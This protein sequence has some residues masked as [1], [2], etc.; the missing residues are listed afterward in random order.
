MVQNPL[1]HV[2]RSLVGS[3]AI[4]VSKRERHLSRVQAMTSGDINIRRDGFLR[5]LTAIADKHD[6]PRIVTIQNPY[7]LLN[8]SF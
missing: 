5:L 4:A 8:R 1:A 7:S 3:P 2:I 6:L